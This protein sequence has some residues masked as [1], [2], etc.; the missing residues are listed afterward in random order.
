MAPT[1][2]GAFIFTMQKL[3]ILRK[4]TTGQRQ[5]DEG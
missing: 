5:K 1:A 4:G 3:Q 2:F